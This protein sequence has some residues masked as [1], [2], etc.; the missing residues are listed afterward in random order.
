[1][2]AIKRN[3][4]PPSL[5]FLSWSMSEP[6]PSRNPAM[7]ASIVVNRLPTVL[8]Y[9]IS[10]PQ[11]SW[12]ASDRQT[13]V[14]SN[15]KPYEDFT[16]IAKFSSRITSWSSRS[17]FGPTRSKSLQESTPAADRRP[18]C[19]TH[20]VLHLRNLLAIE[21]PLLKESDYIFNSTWVG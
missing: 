9:S 18:T 8:S 1:M 19:L 11:A 10:G 13:R 20:I 4:K 16:V 2:V 12:R 7:Y 5:R 3:F 6:S 17:P 21:P 15:Q 14:L